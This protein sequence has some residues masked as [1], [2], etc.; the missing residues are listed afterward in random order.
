[1]SDE[2]TVSESD[3]KLQD[4]TKTHKKWTGEEVKAF[5]LSLGWDQD[6][7]AAEVGAQR[8]T[9]SKWENGRNEISQIKSAA[10]DRVKEKHTKTPKEVRE[11]APTY[12]AQ[13]PELYGRSIEVEAL[14]A[15]ALE[16]QRLLTQALSGH[17]VTP[18]GA[19]DAAAGA[20]AAVVPVESSTAREGAQRPQEKQA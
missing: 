6:Q 16:R 8:P 18:I 11:P 15:Y 19:R 12:R 2:V 14:L 1:M 10:L 9:V 3:D 13:P 20:S 17:H 7:L 5:R 4:H